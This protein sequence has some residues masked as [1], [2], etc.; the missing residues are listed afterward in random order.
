[1][2]M[3]TLNA[4]NRSASCCKWYCI[5]FPLETKPSPLL[6]RSRW[7][8]RV[9]LDC[10]HSRGRRA[11]KIKS[12]IAMK[13][14]QSTRNPLASKLDSILRKK[15]LRC[16]ILSLWS[17]LLY[18]VQTLTLQKGHKYL[19]NFKTWC[20]IRIEKISWTERMYN[21]E[22]LRTVKGKGKVH[23]CTGRTAHRWSSYSSTLF[24]PQH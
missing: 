18:G 13:K 20:W 5:I 24:L 4:S 19:K 2:I 7:G 21:E 15:L 3:H 8:S 14:Q 6:R 11:C 22:I 17:V 1:M 23:P 9:W 16:S 10:S 12:R